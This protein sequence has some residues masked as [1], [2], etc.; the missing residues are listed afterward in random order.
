MVRRGFFWICVV[1]AIGFGGLWV[2]SWWYFVQVMIAV[3]YGHASLDAAKGVMLFE[4]RREPTDIN[5]DVQTSPLLYMAMDDDDLNRFEELF[6]GS[7]V[8][9][10]EDP[11][12]YF[13]YEC[14]LTN[15]WSL[16]ELPLGIGITA[17]SVGAGP[18]GV[19]PHEWIECTF[20]LWLPSLLFLLWPANR[21]ARGV[22]RLWKRKPVCCTV[23]LVSGVFVLSQI[24]VQCYQDIEHRRHRGSMHRLMFALN[25]YKDIYES[26][27]STDELGGLV[28]G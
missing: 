19:G 10:M 9:G 11:E 14:F 21:I 15:A 4:A 23:T 24:A 6:D 18:F 2:A 1:Q 16:F 28:F 7:Y 27:P 26:F 22:R 8:P 3:R 5:V 13:A 20:P 17:G 25:D 12:S